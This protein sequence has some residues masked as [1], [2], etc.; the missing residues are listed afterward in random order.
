MTRT[1]LFE[2]GTEE[3]PAGFMEPGLSFMEKYISRAFSTQRIDHG[4]IL[5]MGTPRRLVL[6]VKEVAET[7]RDKVEEVMGPDGAVFVE[8]EV[9]YPG[10][11]VQTVGFGGMVVP[12]QEGLI[13]GRVAQGKDQGGGFCQKES[14]LEVF[15]FGRK[16][17]ERGYYHCQSQGRSSRGC[18]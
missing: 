17:D 16:G 1:L 10:L 8:G 18:E 13:K 9:S 6:M 15:E 14:L 2:I 3:I 12:V 11:D 7:Q 5:T 4:D